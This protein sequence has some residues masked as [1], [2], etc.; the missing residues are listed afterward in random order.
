[1]PCAAGPP[2][3]ARRLALSA[4]LLVSF[5]AVS[6]GQGGGAPTTPALL[7]TFDPTTTTTTTRTVTTPPEAPP[8]SSNIV[9]QGAASETQNATLPSTTRASSPDSTGHQDHAQQISSTL[10]SPPPT[11][12]NP[13]QQGQQDTTTLLPP[14]QPQ[15]TTTTTTTTTATAPLPTSTTYTSS[16]NPETP[17]ST[18]EAA[19]SPDTPLG[20]LLRLYFIADFDTLAGEM[21]SE[22]ALRESFSAAL[23]AIPTIPCSDLWSVSVRP[24]SLFAD[25]YLGTQE[26]WA[27]LDAQLR[28]GSLLLSIGGHDLFARLPP[29]EPAD[30][31]WQWGP[32]GGCS[33]TCG[34]GTMSR[35]RIIYQPEQLDGVPCPD[36]LMSTASCSLQDCAPF[37]A[38]TTAAPSSGTTPFTSTT[39]KS[40]NTQKSVSRHSSSVSSTAIGVSVLA[41]IVVVSSFL[42]LLLYYLRTS[43]K[44]AQH[45]PISFTGLYTFE[46]FG[47]NR[48]S[49]PE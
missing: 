14:P 37:I 20:L 11:P 42:V 30:C 49:P 17:E 12:S 34:E 24:G 19:A 29:D 22:E 45:E 44:K 39:A 18:T 41:G 47:A 16:T 27:L 31:V 25:L 10:P 26:S 32:W 35:V 4:L 48:T 9:Q 6:G 3:S 1:M 15:V 36:T 8:H 23:C 7:P 33:K 40:P 13:L 28:S 38:P 21:G 5:L 43:K 2:W 46:P